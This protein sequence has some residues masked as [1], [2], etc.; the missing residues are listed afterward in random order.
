MEERPIIGIT[1]G[2]PA[3]IG[4]EIIVKALA[5]P[6]ICKICKPVV[7]GDSGSL[8]LHGNGR[9]VI[10]EIAHPSE[11]DGKVGQIDLIAICR[12]G[13]EVLSPGIPHVR[14]GEAMVDCIITAVEMAKGGEIAAVVTCPINKAL[15]H[16]A[17]YD[18]EGHT[19][20]ISSLTH[21]RDYV[22]MLAG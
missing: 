14:G 13:Q 12:L 8:S 2:D 17:G 21:S 20:L 16:Q 10:R 4:P 5:D 22:M 7:F 3:G 6:G 18:Y 9:L 19:Q 15:M 1:M 11:A